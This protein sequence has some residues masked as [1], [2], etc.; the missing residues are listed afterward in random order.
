[1]NKLDELAFD[2]VPKSYLETGNLV[3]L[4]A[5]T[6]ADTIHPGD[7]LGRVRKFPAEE[8]KLAA[9]SLINRPVNVNHNK[10]S[11]EGAWVIDSEYNDEQIES[12]AYV[13]NTYIDKIKRG[14]IKNCSIEFGW[15][16]ENV[17]GDNITFDGL[18]LKG[19]ALLDETLLKPGARAGDP[20][21]VV[22]LFEK[23]NNFLAE[24]T[25][26]EQE[27]PVEE[28]VTVSGYDSMEQCL[29]ANKDEEDPVAFC[30]ALIVKEIEQGVPKTDTERACAHYN[31]TP[32]EYE[33]NPEK[34]PLPV[35]GTKR[36]GEPFAGY[37]DMEA[38][39]ADNSDK[40]DPAA[41][42]AV[43]MAQ[44][45]DSK[46]LAAIEEAFTRVQ[47]ENESLRTNVESKTNEAKKE[48]KEQ[49]KAEI[50]S[51]IPLDLHRP[52]IRTRRLLADLKEIIS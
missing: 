52:D 33:A 44:A 40:A 38:C 19:I 20:N 2:W 10:K 22:A 9:R 11:I 50:S 3:K 27:E 13:P 34:Y 28:P 37:A 30:N 15:R 5:K 46:K 4:V 49:L 6:T 7:K 41:Y 42:C 26:I 21:S 18:F 16:N 17:E 35:P 1:M 47:T 45:E 51:K 23:T 24:M 39:I 43:I 36:A 48:A 8:L 25:L 14:E 32:E 29:E 12:V 31:I